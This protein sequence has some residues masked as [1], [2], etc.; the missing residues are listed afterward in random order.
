MKQ[1]SEWS[2][3]QESLIFD[4]TKLSGSISKKIKK[5]GGKTL[6][7]KKARELELMKKQ[8]GRI[9]DVSSIFNM[10]IL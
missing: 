7:K 2:K 5:R 3:F 1:D 6:R 4:E 9:D 8:E 10:Y